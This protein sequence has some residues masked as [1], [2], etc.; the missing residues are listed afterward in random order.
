LFT[1]QA[2]HEIQGAVTF[3]AT[4]LLQSLIERISESHPDAM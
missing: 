1:S 3:G 4:T 2:F